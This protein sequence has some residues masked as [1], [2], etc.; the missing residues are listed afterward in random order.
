MFNAPYNLLQINM[1]NVLITVLA[2]AQ[3]TTEGGGR[4]AEGGGRAAGGGRRAAGG[5]RRAAGG[6]RR[7][8]GGGRWAGAGVCAGRHPGLSGSR[9]VQPASW[10]R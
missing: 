1:C 5:G 4:R 10:S 3:E 7:A 6:G 8:A 2:G 9:C